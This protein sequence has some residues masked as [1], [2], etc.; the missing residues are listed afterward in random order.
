MKSSIAAFSSN[1][2]YN[3]ELKTADS[4]KDNSSHILFYDTAGA[5]Y[6][7]VQGEGGKSLFNN[8]E[9]DFVNKLMEY[10]KINTSDLAFISPYS[11]QIEKAKSTL[12]REVKVSTIDSFQGQEK[13]TIIISLVRSNNEGVIGF[14]KDY[15]RMNVAM[16]RAKERLIIIGDSSTVGSDLFYE[17]LL[18]YIESIESYKSVWELM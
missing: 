9:L 3:G 17:R 1:Y 11:S 18:N 4:L 14:L 8:G 2:F 13:H 5:G 16:T 6:E 12:P 7:E 15:R 10:L